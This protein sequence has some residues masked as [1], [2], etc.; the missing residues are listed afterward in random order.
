MNI[1]FDKALK[2]QFIDSQNLSV[3][4]AGYLI[5]ATSKKRITDENNE[6]IKAKNF[7][8]FRKGSR[9]FLTKNIETV[10][11]EAELSKRNEQA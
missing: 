6:V 1:Y 4:S 2:G 8:G 3:D 7:G 5:D 10:I 9:I 11:K